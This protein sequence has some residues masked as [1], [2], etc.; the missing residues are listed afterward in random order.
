MSL[1][2]K[3]GKERLYIT[4]PSPDPKLGVIRQTLADYS[5]IPAE[6]IK[7]I[8]GGGIMKDDSYPISAYG[9]GDGSTLHMVGAAEHPP[10]KNAPAPK[11]APQR[12]TE[13]ALI[14]KIE[15]ELHR[16]RQSLIP[17]LDAFLGTLNS[18]SSPPTP[19]MEREHIRL[20]ELLLQSLLRLDS[21]TPEG[22]WEDARSLRKGAVREVQS[23]LDKLDDGWRERKVVM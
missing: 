2:V 19:E 7:L 17:P 4:L 12:L 14:S 5:H 8:F 22:S 9:I 16:I 11:E 1:T 6:N 23:L 10:S 20:G 13:P 3:W 15:E 21:Y 18:S